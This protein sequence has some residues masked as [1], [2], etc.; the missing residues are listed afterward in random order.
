MEIEI[1]KG[2]EL[3]NIDEL[4]RFLSGLRNTKNSKVYLRVEEQ[5]KKYALCVYIDNNLGEESTPEARKNFNGLHKVYQSKM[6]KVNEK[7]L[8][9]MVIE[10]I[11]NIT[12][13]AWPE[14][15]GDENPLDIDSVQLLS[16]FRLW[17][18]EFEKWWLG[19]G[20]G[21]YNHDYLEE[22]ELFTDKKIKEYLR[23]HGK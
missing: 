20:D 8:D 17:G 16:E 3:V 1:V 19:L 10:T 11:Q 15:Y 13:Q 4:N 23:I 14:I 18:E 21:R 2:N 12:L 9:N 6:N 22:V 7:P 5:D